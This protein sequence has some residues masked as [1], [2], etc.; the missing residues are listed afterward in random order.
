MK[1]EIIITIIDIL[2]QNKIKITLNILLIIIYTLSSTVTALIM[3]TALDALINLNLSLFGGYILVF[4]GVWMVSLISQYMKNITEASI[5]Q[6]SSKFLRNQA[7]NILKNEVTNSSIGYNYSKYINM[8]S[9]DIVTIEE[10]L[11]NF[12]ELL[13]SFFLI[14]FTSLALFWL[15]FRFL[16]LSIILSSILFI[17]P[18]LFQRRINENTKVVSLE[19][20][21][22][23]QNLENW[24]N[25]SI[26]LKQNNALK[27]I[28]KAISFNSDNLSE[29][30]LRMT[31]TKSVFQI[32]VVLMNILSQCSI[33]YLA[34]YLSL[35]GLIPI[36]TIMTIG[37]LTGNFFSSLAQLISITSSIFST[38]TLLEKY[39]FSEQYGEIGH[40]FTLE[41]E[42]IL[43]NL[44][45]SYE[46][47]I[48][49]YPDITIKKNKKYVISGDSGTGK[50][51]LINLI[52]G[53]LSNY[54]GDMYWDHLN[55]KELGSNN[56]RNS[57]SVMNQNV[58]IFNTSIKN[59]I[60]L[61]CPY[62]EQDFMQVLRSSQLLEIVSSLKDK[63]NTVLDNTNR[64]LSGG[65]LQRL[66]LAR[67]LYQAKDI[68]I[69]DE[70]TSNLDANTSEL[71]Y[72]DLFSNEKLTVIMITHNITDYLINVVDE[73]IQ[74]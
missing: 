61:D 29:A 43:R 62:D 22:L 38:N 44:N 57:I 66:S 23:T 69:I 65:Q 9:N 13:S 3:T 52:S 18:S 60:I 15:D 59:N 30:I 51:T 37:T 10:G 34:G 64:V 36:S 14:L 5:I 46:N 7:I 20:E 71:I 68:I 63:E 53:N 6:S 2:K 70:G 11:T 28:N 41:N 40:R 50:T 17:I 4:I 12:F 25:G 42:I 1:G 73:I 8:A 54:N 56:L 55:Y 16:I 47:K 58:Y 31:K 39:A 19:R 45:Y 35:K 48:L 24:V 27:L 26:Y 21:K 67:T 72:K 32:I 33:F 74:L 49:N